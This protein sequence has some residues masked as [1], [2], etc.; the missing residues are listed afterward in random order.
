MEKRASVA[1]VGTSHMDFTAYVDEF[2][3]PGETVVG[4]EFA[5]AP[6]GKG[7]N[8]AVAVSRMGATCYLVSKVGRD[9]VG[10]SLFENAA[11]NGIRT[12]FLRRDPRS[13]SGVA[14][15]Y[16]NARGENVI[17]VAPGVDRLISE[18][19]VRYAER[20]I[21]S[22][23]VVLAQLEIPLA[24]AE[25]AMRYAKR[26][27][28]TTILNPAPASDL[29]DELLHNVDFLTPNLGELAKLT[30]IKVADDE[31]M[32]RAAGT[33]L[34]RGLGHVIVTLGKRGS[35]LVTSAGSELIP[36]YEVDAVDTVGA[37][38]AFNGALAF[39]ISLGCGAREAARFANLV[40]AL[41]VTRKGAQSGIPTLEEALAF[42]RSMGAED[43]PK[44]IVDRSRSPAKQR[45]G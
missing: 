33:L 39:A 2:P 42:A 36:S 32:L 44:A 40:A 24:T 9:F 27:G 31:S 23:S 30:R 13:H 28:K 19:D 3:K 37:G 20:G 41:K 17:A 14:L 35:M 34:D 18:E 45:R 5:M 25:F 8:Q 21:S 1:V 26:M 6:G 12:D 10:E 38:D 7:A 22:S 15:I 43:L 16:V 4:R 11:K 29:K